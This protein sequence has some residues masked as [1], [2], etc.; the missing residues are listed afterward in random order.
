MIIE[1]LFCS[2]LCGTVKCSLSIE[3]GRECPLGGVCFSQ[4][5]SE[6]V[7][8]LLQYYS[9]K[10]ILGE[11]KE[12]KRRE[13]RDTAKRVLGNLLPCLAGIPASLF[14]SLTSLTFNRWSQFARRETPRWQEMKPPQHRGT[15]L[16]HSTVLLLLSSPAFILLSPISQHMKDLEEKHGGFL[17]CLFASPLFV[18]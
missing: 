6:E 3:R 1:T 18:L 17:G 7:L 13:R 16:P 4:C 12:S 8:M 11:V 2:F 5:C 15:W 14:L 10:K 9:L